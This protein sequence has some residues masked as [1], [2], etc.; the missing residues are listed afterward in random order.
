ML[1]SEVFLTEFECDGN[2][3]YK[4]QQ[5]IIL[6]GTSKLYWGWGGGGGEWDEDVGG[7]EKRKN[8]WDRKLHLIP[9][10]M[11]STIY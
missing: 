1:R 5:K 4:V 10:C 8:M 6:V 3:F 9:L 2:T 11:L 7:G